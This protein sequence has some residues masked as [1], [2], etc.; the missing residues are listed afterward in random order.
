[1]LRPG[2]AADPLTELLAERHG[3]HVVQAAPG[4]TADARRY[5]PDTG[6]LFLSPWLS[7]G[8]RAFQLATQLAFLEQR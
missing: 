1:E 2:R 8:Q 7:D 4:R 3:V 5:D 6:L